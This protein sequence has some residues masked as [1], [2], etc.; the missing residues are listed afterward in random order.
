MVDEGTHYSF[1]GKYKDGVQKR[2]NARIPVEINATF[3]YMD[4]ENTIN[5]SCLLTSLSTGGLAF[6]SSCVLLEGD[7]IVITFLLNSKIIIESCKITRIRG[8]EVG[9]KFNS[10][11]KE[12]VEVIQRYIYKKLFL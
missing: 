4:T 12:N 5:D 1:R 7:V 9:V 8:R 2:K 11:G 6:K 3:K 10:P